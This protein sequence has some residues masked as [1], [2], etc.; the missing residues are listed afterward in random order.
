MFAKVNVSIKRSGKRRLKWIF[1]T[2]RIA[3]QLSLPLQKSKQ[4]VLDVGQRIRKYGKRY[5]W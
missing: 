1:E 4:Q 5:Y 2:A 3:F